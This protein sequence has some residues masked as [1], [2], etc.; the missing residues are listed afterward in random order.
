MHY[1]TDRI[2]AYFYFVGFKICLSQGRRKR[3]P[4]VVGGWT[5]PWCLWHHKRTGIAMK[6]KEGLSKVI[7]RSQ[8]PIYAECGFHT[9]F[10]LSLRPILSPVTRHPYCPT[11]TRMACY[12]AQ[13]K[14]CDMEPEAFS[15]SQLVISRNG[16]REKGYW[17][18]RLC[19]GRE[20]LQTLR[21]IINVYIH[22]PFFLQ[23]FILVLIGTAYM[24]LA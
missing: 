2:A 10:W 16:K 19:L 13:R 15:S 8:V 6:G 24:H 22:N 21:S 20:L 17:V 5:K 18:N 23:Y 12:I 14:A 9:V 11:S 3:V 4:G 1:K 7:N